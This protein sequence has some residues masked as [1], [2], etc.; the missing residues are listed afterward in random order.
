M[1]LLYDSNAQETRFT[2]RYP[3]PYFNK[4]KNDHESRVRTSQVEPKM[5]RREDEAQASEDLKAQENTAQAGLCADTIILTMDGELP[6]HDIAPGDRV[7]TRDAGMVVL[8]GVRRKRVTCDAVQIKAGSFGHKRPS[9]DVVLPCGTKLLIRDWRANAIFGTKQA[10]IAAQDLQDGEYV[11][12][13]PQQEWTLSNSCSTSLTSFM[14]A[15]L[16]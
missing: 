13:L 2:R 10:L 6:A 14:Q 4:V 9:E 7:I 11:K 16:K 12:I 15:V 5:A 8:L 1:W 3:L